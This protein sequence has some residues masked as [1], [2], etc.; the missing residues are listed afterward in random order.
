[1]IVISLSEEEEE[2]KEAATAK[3]RS[4]E[5][6]SKIIVVRIGSSLR[7]QFCFRELLSCLA[8]PAL[9]GM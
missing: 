6:T 3:D 9:V 8:P 2:E 7:S 5:E 1:M 4:F